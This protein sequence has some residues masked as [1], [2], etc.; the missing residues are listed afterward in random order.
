M[1][2]FSRVLCEKW[3]FLRADLR[4]FD[5]LDIGNKYKKIRVPQLQENTSPPLSPSLPRT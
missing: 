2:H 1:P 4:P 5:L 3:G